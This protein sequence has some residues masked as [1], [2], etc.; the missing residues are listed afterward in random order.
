MLEKE[1]F[2]Y[3][4]EL[5]WNN[6]EL[7]FQHADM[8]EFI[9]IIER[10]FSVKVII[11]GERPAA[12]WRISGRFREGSLEDVMESLSFSQRINYELK[13]DSVLLRF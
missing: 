11:S 8:E 1:L 9:E 6:G 13:G 7:V 12:S 10:W 3:S 5:S 4:E 2:N